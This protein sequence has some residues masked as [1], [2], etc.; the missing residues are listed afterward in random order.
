MNTYWPYIPMLAI[1]GLGIAA[2][3]ALDKSSLFSSSTAGFQAASAAIGAQSALPLTRAQVLVGSGQSWIP[4]VI[5]GL[6]VVAGIWLAYSHFR[7]FRL[8]FQES[9]RF[10]NNHP[11][12]DIVLMLTVTASAV[13][14]R[15]VT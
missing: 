3:G 10:I 13:L 7:R 5:V 14:S 4:L 1:V 11:V 6:G 2:N 8:A 12:L 9:E 15:V